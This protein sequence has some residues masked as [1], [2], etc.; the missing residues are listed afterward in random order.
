MAASYYLRECTSL[1]DVPRHYV[2]D[3]WFDDDA[4]YFTAVDRSE[5][6]SRRNRFWQSFTGIRECTSLDFIEQDLPLQVAQF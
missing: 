6:L 3:Q 4:V 2:H 1:D 5:F